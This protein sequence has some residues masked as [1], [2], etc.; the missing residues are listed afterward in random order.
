[1]ALQGSITLGNGVTIPNAYLIVNE[2]YHSYHVD[3]TYIIIH[4]LIYND[5]SSFSLGKPE[6]LSLSFKCVGSDYTTFFDESVLD[7]SGKTSLN[8]SYAWLKTLTQYS[9]WSEI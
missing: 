9:A 8:Q 6:V 2:I 4:I 5:I 7:D 3:D 1:M